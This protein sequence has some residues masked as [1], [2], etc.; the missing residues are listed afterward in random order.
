M[1]NSLFKLMRSMYPGAIPS[2]R[3]NLFNI[4]LILDLSQIQSLHLLVGHMST[5]INRNLPLR[6][7]LVPST[8]S[9]D[10]KST[11]STPDV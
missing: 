5:I 8:E 6:F 2:V 9:K 10:G 7:G 3:L 11:R 4:I 1:L